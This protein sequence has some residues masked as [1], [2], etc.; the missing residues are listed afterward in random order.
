[1]E[2]EEG[3]IEKGGLT[4][5]TNYCTAAF[6]GKFNLFTRSN[7]KMPAACLIPTGFETGS[8]LLT[9]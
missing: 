9:C 3:G 1:M 8:Q 4:N 7:N 6:A 2:N 5:K